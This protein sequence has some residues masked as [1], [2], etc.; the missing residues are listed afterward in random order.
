MKKSPIFALILILAFGFMTTG[1]LAFGKKA[2]KAK[3]PEAAKAADKA[4]AKV[5]EKAKPAPAAPAK[6]ESAPTLKAEKWD[7]KIAAKVG[8]REITGAE[9]D[10]AAEKDLM[11][12][13]TQIYQIKKRVL[14]QMIEKELYEQEAKATGKSVDEI[15]VQPQA[16]FATVSDD[17]IEVYYDSNAAKFQGKPLDQVK[18]QIRNMLIQQKAD[19]AKAEFLSQLKKKFPTQIFMLEPKVEIDI[20][21]HPWRGAKDA[22]VTIVEFSEFQCPFCKKFMPTTDQI[23]KDYPND[24]KHVFRHNPLP[25]HNN[26]KAASKASICA[27]RQGKFWEM[28]AA[29]F[30]NQ[31]ALDEV[32][33]RASAEKIKLDMSKYDNCMKDPE[34]DKYLE[35]EVQYAQSVGARGTPTSFVNGVLFS[36]AKPYEELK[37][38]VDEKLGKS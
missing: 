34:V 21:D 8:D 7:G 36:G 4:P 16:T 25:F 33:N 9:L 17:A 22:K 5:E 11:P 32:S 24:V 14:D 29:L 1:F 28:R 15:K 37:R 18:E 31:Q 3:T 20:A 30:E 38:V 13:A 23:V 35:K 6:V 10:V 12:M 27:D 19:K 26:A 2:D